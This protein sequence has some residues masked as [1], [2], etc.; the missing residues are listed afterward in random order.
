ME[1]EKMKIKVTS[2]LN[3]VGV[4]ILSQ[5]FERLLNTVPN[6]NAEFL[7]PDHISTTNWNDVDVLWNIG[8]FFNIDCLLDWI[9][10][11]YPK[12]KT[13]NTWVGSDILNSA[14]WWQERHKCMR[15]A[16]RSIDIHVADGVNLQDELKGQFNFDSFY[17]PSVPDPIPLTP[18]RNINP[19]NVAVYCGSNPEFYRVP[20]TV[21]VARKLPRFHFNFYSM[22]KETIAP[23]SMP[24]NGE[25]R[26][27]FLA[28]E[29]LAE[30]ARNDYLL[31]LPQH[32][33]VSLMLIEF[34]QMG[35]AVVSNI[36]TPF[37]YHVDE[38]VTA[39]AVV[40]QLQRAYT[41]TL[42]KGLNVEASKYYHSEYGFEK[43]KTYILPILEEL[44]KIET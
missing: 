3:A 41:D 19:L 14:M 9:K 37:V 42:K 32:G 7:P 35:R 10:A 23:F 33:S 24:L 11:Y 20:L 1:A 18:L 21:E 44:R 30:Y 6:V 27:F 12:I 43:A 36:K 25:F 29:K 17:V 22:F 15:C 8:F 38:P 4:P 16:T 2:G 26:G 31:T 5:T 13:V 39:E 28:G 40:E 34:M